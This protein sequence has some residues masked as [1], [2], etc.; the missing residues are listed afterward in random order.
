M[1]GIVTFA[2]DLHALAIQR[3]I[4]QL[5]GC[6]CH[7]FESDKI[8]QR[9]SIALRITGDNCV[10]TAITS[11]G[12][13]LDLSDLGALWLRRPQA[14]QTISRSFEDNVAT[15]L[16]DNDCNGALK[17]LL[18]SSFRGKWISA[19][20][21]LIRASDKISQLRPAAQ[22]GFRIPDTLV[23]QSQSEVSAFATLH[24]ATGIIVK[25]V[26]GASGPFLLTR[27]MPDASSFE[28]E[29]YEAA[30]AI[31]QELIP[32]ARHIRLLCFGEECLAASID[33]GELDWRPNL[34]VP[35][36]PWL[37]S[38]EVRSMVRTTLDLLGLEMGVVDLKET[39]S[40]ELVWLEVN[41]QGQF[42]FL[43]PLAKMKVQEPFAQYLA[44]AGRA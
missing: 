5:G 22:A 3:S 35:V 37:V 27:K 7:I 33:S 8:A 23:S 14:V 16:V 41:P 2:Q 43:E 36:H 13:T 39:P 17:G 29:A 40:G 1:V 6:A 15:A 18:V 28:E 20:D 9:D 32:G 34:H 38:A 30:P 10:G 31:Y 4:R 21:A 19:F 42:L 11:E 12:L 24:Q 26:V 25:T 44:S